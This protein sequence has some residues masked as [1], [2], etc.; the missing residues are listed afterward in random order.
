MIANAVQKIDR[1]KQTKN[2]YVYIIC[3]RR[4]IMYNQKLTDNIV[5]LINIVM[6]EKELAIQRYLYLR[7]MY[8]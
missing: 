2:R 8:M 4:G 7:D 6:I 3:I 5:I 1:L